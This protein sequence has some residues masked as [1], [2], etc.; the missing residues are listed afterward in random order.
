MK[1]III[2]SI[3]VSI[4]LIVIFFNA[5]LQIEYDI[6]ILGHL[7]KSRSLTDEEMNWLNKH[8]KI[9]YGADNSSPPLRFVD[10]LDGQ[11]RGLVVDYIN[12]L[13]IELGTEIDYK[14]VDSWGEALDSLTQKKSDFFDMIISEERK[15][16]FDFTDTVYSLRGAILISKH[17]KFIDN[18]EDLGGKEVLVPKGDYAVDFLN[19]KLDN[20]KFIY[21][22]DMK[23]AIN[24]LL[25]NEADAV[26]GD[27]PVIIHYLEKLHA[28]N[29]LKILNNLMYESECAFAVPKSEKNLLSILNKGIY[30]LKKKNTMVKIQQKWFGFSV[31][32]D[33]KNQTA[34]IN[35]IIIGFCSALL[36]FIYFF[37]SW[38]NLLKKEV[39]K[40]TE[41]LFISKNNL[42]K[43]FDAITHLMI[44]IDKNYNIIN[45]N[46]AFCEFLNLDKNNVLKK[47]IED[48]QG[49]ITHN[50]IKNMINKTSKGKQCQKEI[51]FEGKLYEITTFPLQN[52]TD[53]LIVIQ[54][55]TQIKLS[56]QQLL[57]TDKMVAIGQLAGGIAH[58]I[59]N[60]LGLIR[61]HC[62][63]LKTNTDPDKI[64]KTI[65]IIENSVQK[66]SDIIDNL[67]NFSR[68]SHSDVEEINI[69]KF[70]TNVM[71]LQKRIFQKNNIKTKIEC[72]AKL[73]CCINQESLKHILVNLITNAIDAM[74]EGGT[75]DIKCKVKDENLLI[76]CSDSGT[77]INKYDLENIFNP[78]FTTKKPGK[79]TG[80][81][82]Y[83][84][85]NEIQ[86]LSGNIRVTSKINEGT[87]FYIILPLR[88]GK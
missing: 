22:P 34:K 81:G 37:Y 54:D 46:Q 39:A 59:R 42:Q 44:V 31:P 26:V 73:T 78:F 75:L 83:I 57:H 50:K 12:A 5:F 30:K 8:G 80:L 88:K 70:I 13:S 63:L 67:L 48:F 79:G 87:S 10:E 66:A 62:Y 33:K 23:S 85:Y 28:Q 72:D 16:I 38:N 7:S 71:N 84:T 45:V 9:V 74:P 32:F 25:N 43:T 61:S 64:K 19:S 52:N 77:G 49:V 82:L 14:S 24:K 65:K 18:Y 47:N 41:E 6:N 58:E 60:P 40:R 53:I 51:K 4:L 3:I 35:L 29:D 21:T 15:K 55:I 69:K 17:K 11:Y 20:V 56:E 36:L 76:T 68:I 86:K 2:S 27:E 1:K